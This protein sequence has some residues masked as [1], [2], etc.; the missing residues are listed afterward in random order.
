MTGLIAVSCGGRATGDPS[1]STSTAGRSFGGSGGPGGAGG[2]I[3]YP[4]IGYCFAKGTRIATATGSVAIEDVRIGDRVQAFDFGSG[5]VVEELVT[6]VF[7]HGRQPVGELRTATGSLRVTANHPI[8]DASVGRFVAAGS[9]S[10]P[11]QA[12]ELASSWST[13]PSVLS[14]FVPLNETET[15]YNFT[16]ANA[17]TYFA[18]GL[19]VHNKQRCGY[20]GDPP[21]C[22]CLQPAECGGTTSVGA[23]GGTGGGTGGANGGTSG[24]GTEGGASSEIGGGAGLAGE[25]FVGGAPSYSDAGAG[26]V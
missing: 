25:S 16:V 6:E 24:G 15:V 12:L 2:S 14:G 11:F 7:E 17:H 13:S 26:G 10:A 19:L 22:P 3:A 21:D 4:P 18:E 5:K 23:N 8:Y 20:P 1:A 9:L